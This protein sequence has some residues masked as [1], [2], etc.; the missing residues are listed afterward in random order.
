MA[1][2]DP[3]PTASS[4]APLVAEWSYD[5][6]VAVIGDI[7]GQAEMLGRLL[8]RL[9]ASMPVLLTG[10]LGDRGPDTRGVLDQLV[11]RDARGVCGNHD[12]WLRD[13]ANGRGFKPAVLHPVMGGRATLRSYGAKGPTLEQVIAQGALVPRT[14]AALLDA[15]PVAAGLTVLGTEYWMAHAGVPEFADLPGVAD[16]DIVPYLAQHMPSSLQWARNYPRAV[17][18]LGRTLVMGHT[19]QVTPLD[20]GTVLAIDTGAGAPFGGALTAVILPERR[21]ITVR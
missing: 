16:E 4:P 20:T 14:H 17:P 1:N 11:A 21:F 2:A 3:T 10:D 7:H 13:W 15:M 9:P 8:R 19:P 12:I 6:P 18:P 5:E